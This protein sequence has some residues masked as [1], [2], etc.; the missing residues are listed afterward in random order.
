[1]QSTFLKFEINKLTSSHESSS[2]HTHFLLPYV[3]SSKDVL[4]L[5][6]LPQWQN[7]CSFHV[8]IR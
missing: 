3:L 8:G 7:E 2:G 5:A 1:M 4:N 6:P